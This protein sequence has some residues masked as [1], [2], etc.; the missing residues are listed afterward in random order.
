MADYSCFNIEN[1]TAFVTGGTRGIGLAIA[2]ALQGAGARVIIHGM[3][4]ESTLAVA[5]EHGFE[6]EYA[7]LRNEQERQLLA[8]RL[9]KRLDKLD[10]FFNNAGYETHNT[11]ERAQEANLD[12]IY[13]VNARSPYLL[14][15]D[16]LDLLKNSGQ[17]SV[18]N[19]T[20][21][22]QDIPVKGNSAYCIAKASL[23]MFTRVAAL[24]L[25]QWNI[26]VNNL[27][28]GAIVTDINRE[29]VH[30]LPFQSWIPM[31]RTGTVEDIAGPALF[32]A[33]PASCYM[34]GATLV[35]D[36]GYSHNLLR[37]RVGED[38]QCMPE[39][40]DAE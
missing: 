17:A 32:L 37:Y 38:A 28:P 19:V 26:R 27:A 25:A 5:R 14:V 10:I 8:S 16:L 2:R 21:I 13:H 39:T 31:R 35:I 9:H 29:L 23:A 34:T 7:D 6:A 40:M 36:G 18:V 20:S 22:H 4:E 33:S 30:A 3:R 15:R 24:E 1:Q 12:D 11:I